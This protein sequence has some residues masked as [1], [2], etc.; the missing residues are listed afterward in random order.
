MENGVSLSLH[1][2]IVAWGKLN[3]IMHPQKIISFRFNLL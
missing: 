2:I 1:D 3:M